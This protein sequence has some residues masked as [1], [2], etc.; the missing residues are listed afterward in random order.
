MTNVEFPGDALK[1]GN[2]SWVSISTFTFP[3]ES[4]NASWHPINTFR[5]QMGK[6]RCEVHKQFSQCHMEKKMPN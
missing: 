4:G 3:R 6:L 1:Y 5:L 2:S